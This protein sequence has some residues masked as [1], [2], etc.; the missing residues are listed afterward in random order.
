[1]AKQVIKQP[2]GKFAIF[3]SGTDT[4]HYTDLTEHQV[5]AHF[6]SRAAD[7]ARREILDILENVKNDQPNKVYYQFAMTWEDAL[8]MDK[9]NREPDEPFD[10][11]SELY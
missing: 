2:N 3:S 11:H 10:D 5:V 8:R 4:F 1:M 7:D 9:E 6:V